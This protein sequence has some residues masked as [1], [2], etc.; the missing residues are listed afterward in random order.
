MQD[1]NSLTTALISLL[2]GLQSNI[3]NLKPEQ[4][5]SCQSDVFS[6]SIGEHV[7]HSLDHIQILL[8]SI[9]ANFEMSNTVFYDRRIRGTEVEKNVLVAMDTITRLIAEIKRLSKKDLEQEIQIEH[10]IQGSGEVF[11]FDS[12]PA[13][14]LFFTAHHLI[15][16]NAIVSAMLGEMGIKCQKNFGV[17]PS[18]IEYNNRS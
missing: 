12:N 1:T 17:A 14:E 15:H 4:Y 11:L 7:R 18:T 16:H 6:G 2:E 3:C 13:R 8:N 9:K 5:H 10:M